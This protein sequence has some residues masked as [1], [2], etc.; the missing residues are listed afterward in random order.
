MNQNQPLRKFTVDRLVPFSY[1]ND[2]RIVY[3]AFFPAPM[4]GERIAI[5]DGETTITG[6]IGYRI[7]GDP[8]CIEV[9]VVPDDR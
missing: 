5:T 6:K 7:T 9:S 3:R 1:P 2:S 8:E 4:F